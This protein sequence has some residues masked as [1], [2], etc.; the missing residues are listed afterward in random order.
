MSKFTINVPGNIIE[1]KRFYWAIKNDGYTRLLSKLVGVQLTDKGIAPLYLP[2]L[3]F[4]KRAG[5][6]YFEFHLNKWKSLI[7]LIDK[8]G[9]DTKIFDIREEYDE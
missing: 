7:I 5:Q 3:S 6:L 4:E 9:I 1:V 8:N 2:V